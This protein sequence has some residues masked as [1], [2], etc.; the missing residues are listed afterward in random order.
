[1]QDREYV[2][3]LK[4]LYNEVGIDCYCC[5]VELSHHPRCGMLSVCG[6]Q[7]CFYPLLVRAFCA[8]GGVAWGAVQCGDSAAPARP[9]GADIGARSRPRYGRLFGGLPDLHLHPR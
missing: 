8:S 7:T 6:R 3:A 4:N 5:N 1:M 9:D 2:P